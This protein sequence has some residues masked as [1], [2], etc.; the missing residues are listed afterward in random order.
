M[1]AISG[2]AY[3]KTTSIQ[4][5]AFPVVLSE[6]DIIGIAKTG[7]GKTAAFV[8]P[9]IVHIMDQPE[10]EK[11]EGPIG[12]ICAPTREL[13]HLIYLEAKKFSKI[14]VSAVYGGMSK[15]EQFNELKA[16]GE[17]VVATPG[18]SKRDAR[19]GGGKRAKG[20]GGGGNRGVRGV[21]F[22]L[23]IGY[24][25]ESKSAP[26]HVVPGRSAAVNSL[27]TGMTAQ[28][29]SSFVAAS[30]G[31]LNARHTP[32]AS[33]QVNFSKKLRLQSAEETRVKRTQKVLKKEQEKDEDPQAE[34]FRFCS[35]RCLKV[36]FNAMFSFTFVQPYVLPP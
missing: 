4:C 26:L 11:E 12:V 16:G 23:G 35:G 36:K 10:L 5:Q 27:R 15:L 17:I 2:Q 1:K 14:R 28:F 31:T 22:G 33:S 32:P 24:N 20:R 18:R 19:K 8:L 13:A 34:I 6:R 29:K 30:S 9:M 25:A 7:S 21:D 3:E